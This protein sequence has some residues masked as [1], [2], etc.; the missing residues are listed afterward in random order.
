MKNGNTEERKE[1]YLYGK[2]DEQL[3]DAVLC[4][5]GAE[6]KGMST[7]EFVKYATERVI[8]EEGGSSKNKRLR[9]M[10]R[11]LEF[12]SRQYHRSRVKVFAQAYLT[13]NDEESLRTL[14]EACDDAGIEMEDALEG[15]EPDS[16]IAEL[17][18]VNGGLQRACL[19]L[20]E[21][22]KPDVQYIAGEM[23][24]MGEDAG[25]SRRMLETAKRRLKIEHTDLGG[26]P[27]QFGWVRRAK[28]EE[29]SAET[30]LVF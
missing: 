3:Y 24:Q 15:M 4:Y 25:F 9:Q 16:A 21:Q 30:E 8:H 7:L 28:E 6:G 5:C 27:K 12:N 11:D 10:S 13:Q 22:M 20:I 19:W 26:N 1:R 17:S 29:K 23:Y 18:K 14:I 2:I